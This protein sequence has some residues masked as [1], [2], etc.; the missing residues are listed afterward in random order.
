MKK[1][2]LFVIESLVCAGGE[3]SLTT[4][5][6]LLDY[7]RYDVDLQLFSYGGELE[8]LLPKEVNM[9]PRLPY[10]AQ[11]R[12]PLPKQAKRIFRAPAEYKALAARIMYSAELR[13]HKMG[14]FQ[15]AIAFWKHTAKCFENTE[16]E[17]DI[18]VAYAQGTPTFYVADCVKAKRKIAWINAS[19]K[20][21]GKYRDFSIKEYKKFDKISCVSE[22]GKQDF[23]D[24]FPMFAEKLFVTKDIND[25]DFIFRMAKEPS[26]AGREMYVPDSCTK[27][28]TVGRFAWPKGYDIAVEAC[29][30]L[31][32]RGKHFKWFVLGKGN[33]EQQIREHVKRLQI[34]DDFIILGVRANP[35]PY[36]DQA[37]IYVQ[38][39]RVE[40][41]GLAIAES[42]MLN[43]PVVT[44]RF[45]AVYAQMVDGENGLVVDM[46]PEAVADGIQ[47]LLE[48]RE[49]YDHIVE[50]QSREKKGNKEEIE[51]FYKLLGDNGMA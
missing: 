38:T 15:Q 18:A 22:S 8:T 23:L 17:Y 43:T 6:N 50:Y 36:Y 13:I 46:T 41:F 48:D 29:S 35:Y 16:K 49:L 33:H 12:G 30:I 25:P 7:E 32:K 39:S 9:L 20:L 21:S 45:D 4:L 26:E 24:C 11:C 44:T 28:L 51:K 10:F 19:Y 14:S 34:Q 47:R 2:I 3:K 31:K 27:I 37:D 5:L 42:R 1:K 40:G